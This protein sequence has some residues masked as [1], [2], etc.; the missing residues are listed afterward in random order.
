MKQF[1]ALILLIVSLTACKS[2]A[3]KYV[4][5]EENQDCCMMKIPIGKSEEKIE[6][7]VADN[8]FPA[9]KLS[10]SSSVEEAKNL[11]FIDVKLFIDG[12]EISPNKEKYEAL[13][14]DAFR[15]EEYKPIAKEDCCENLEKKLG[16]D[17]SKTPESNLFGVK[18]TKSYESLKNLP[19]NIEVLLT[20]ITDKGT[21]EKRWKLQLTTYEKISDPIRFH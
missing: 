5:I 15:P 14:F 7:F 8:T 21:F 20:A 11:K 6:L 1:L 10:Y 17:K 19:P 9:I 3:H 4:T 18:I 13:F 12:K 2:M 16:F